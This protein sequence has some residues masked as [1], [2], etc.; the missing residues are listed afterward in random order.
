MNN[1]NSQWTTNLKCL[2]ATKEESSEIFNSQMKY[3]TQLK[4]YNL[5]PKTFYG[6]QSL[7]LQ[8]TYNPITYYLY[9]QPN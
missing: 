2:Q 7:S 3:I 1:C 4:N 8:D 9:K 5:T 6:N